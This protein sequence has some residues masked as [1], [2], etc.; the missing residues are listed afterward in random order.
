MI[1]GDGIHITYMRRRYRGEEKL[2]QSELEGEEYM[3]GH[4]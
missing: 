3:V 1:Q 2:F 4:K